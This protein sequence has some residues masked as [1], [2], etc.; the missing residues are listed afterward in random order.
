[1]NQKVK[2]LIEKYKTFTINEYDII[3]DNIL[4]IIKENLPDEN[5]KASNNIEREYLNRIY[6]KT[7]ILRFLLHEKHQ[8]LNNLIETNEQ[9]IKYCRHINE[10]NSLY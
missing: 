10:T 3:E 7:N 8:L 5:D 2:N 1:M 6:D 9:L 4:N